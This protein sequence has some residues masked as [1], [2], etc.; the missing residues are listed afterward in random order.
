M[1]EYNKK[2][3]NNNLT[4]DINNDT[5]N[6][7]NKDRNDNSDQHAEQ[8]NSS[9]TYYYAY[10]SSLNN[11]NHRPEQMT[12]GEPVSRDEQLRTVKA[13]I[14]PATPPPP[15]T[16]QQS[17]GTRPFTTSG[18]MNNGNWKVAAP[19]KRRSFA[20]YFIAF[21]AGAL[22]VGGLMYTADVRNWFGGNTPSATQEAQRPQTVDNSGGDTP[23][24]GGTAVTSNFNLPSNIS[25]L[26]QQSSPA[27]VKIETFEQR[28]AQRRGASLFDDPFFR[29]FFGDNYVIP[30]ETEQGGRVQTGIGT[31][32]IFESDGYILT[33]QHVVGESSEILV[34]IQG[35]EEPLK[36]KLLGA[37]YE[38]D[39]AVI[40]VEGAEANSFPTL[41]LGS[42]DDIGIGDWV[43]AI[44]NPYGFDH[45]T[46]VGVISAK[47]RP[48]DIADPQGDRHYKHLLQTDASINPGNSGGPLLNLAGEVVGINTAVSAQAQGIGFA[49]PTS[50]VQNVLADLKAGNEIA[51]EPAPFVGIQG[52]TVNE[53]IVQQFGLKN[54]TGSI[55]V[56]V[57]YNSPAYKAGLKQY[58]IIT[59]VNG[60]SYKTYPELQKAITELQVGEVAKFEIIRQG[61]VEV[62]EVEI[63]DMNK[64]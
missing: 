51:K 27:V 52:E 22:V 48:I 3:E 1:D 49:I 40:K 24:S 19:P 5:N 64:M 59:S 13:E 26:F 57:I 42:S 8:P 31:G 7:T 16:Q 50:T 63:G 17:S 60:T 10:G 4:N 53:E 56:N 35:H 11:R 33:N 58:D 15:L 55:I 36:A 34:T 25:Q 46:T 39:L 28:Q 21:L 38:L 54:V 43:V 47:E 30:E 9:S 44:G 6:D 32:F 37:S 20:S 18:T 62:I 45:T 12:E 41:P 2:D 23:A 14:N 61:E 29:Q